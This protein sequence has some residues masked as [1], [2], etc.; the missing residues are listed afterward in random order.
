MNVINF[1]KAKGFANFALYGHC[2]GGWVGGRSAGQIND[3]KAVGVVHAYG[4][5]EEDV[6]NMAVPGYFLPCSDDPDMVCHLN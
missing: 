1:Y 3:L 2:W 5:T 6:R 4:V